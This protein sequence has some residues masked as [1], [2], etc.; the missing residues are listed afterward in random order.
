[1]KILHALV[2][3]VF[4][5]SGMVGCQTSAWHQQHLSSAVNIKAQPPA[6][7]IKPPF[8]PNHYPGQT[9]IYVRLDKRKAP[10]AVQQQAQLFIDGKPQSFNCPV[11]LRPGSH[12]LSFNRTP[13]PGYVTPPSVTV[14]IDKCETAI[15]IVNFNPAPECDSA[16]RPAVKAAAKHAP[17][18]AFTAAGM[19][20]T[21]VSAG[22]VVQSWNQLG[23]GVGY[24]QLQCVWS[25]A[26]HP[27]AAR[28]WLVWPTMYWIGSSAI[29]VG[30]GTPAV[31]FESVA[32]WYPPGYPQNW[33]L[34]NTYIG[35]KTTATVT[36]GY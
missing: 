1:M 33:V 20:A 31:G 35:Y 10:R 36:Y 34:V 22:S 12:R 17:E 8:E 27:S 23:S 24:G 6:V 29:P 19:G 3:A 7:S 9:G 11:T 15:V 16:A 13:I 32:G 28:W 30:Q 14:T 5:S 21:A 18:H 2:F 4:V 25:G 26:G